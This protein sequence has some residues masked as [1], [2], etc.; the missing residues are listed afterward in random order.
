MLKKIENLDAAY[1]TE[2]LSPQIQLALILGWDKWSLGFYDGLY[3]DDAAEELL[4]P[5]EKKEKRRAEK[6]KKM[7]NLSVRE[8]DS[9]R[10]IEMQKR[11]KK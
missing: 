8:R 11:Y 5:E 3:G 9:L 2:N 4:S 1:N 7:Q 6:I 10:F